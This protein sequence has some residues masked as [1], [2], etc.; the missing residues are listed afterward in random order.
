MDV[1]A[2]RNLPEF[3]R[4]FVVS[5]TTADFAGERGRG[6]LKPSE[7]EDA[8]IGAIK[9]A[10]RKAFSEEYSAL[11]RQK[12]LPKNSKLLWV[13]PRLDEKGLIRYDGCLSQDARF[14]IILPRKNQDT[15]FIVK[16]YH[17]EGKDASAALIRLW[18]PY[19]SDFGKH[20]RVKKLENGRSS[21][22]DKKTES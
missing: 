7:I 3:K 22:M 12:E 19:Q 6:E 13:E 8:R 20:L 18:Q 5:W 9:S 10:Q 2:G 15:K 14:P 21:A 4:G 16:H 1:Q 17:E 11:Y